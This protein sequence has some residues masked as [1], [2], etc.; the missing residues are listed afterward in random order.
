MHIR[1][2]IKVKNENEISNSCR[3][4][5]SLFHWFDANHIMNDIFMQ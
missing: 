5:L 1:K 2:G 4:I 3:F